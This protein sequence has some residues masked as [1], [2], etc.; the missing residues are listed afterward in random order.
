MAFQT[1]CLKIG[2]FQ[3]KIGSF[4]SWNNVIHVNSRD[5]AFSLSFAFFAPR[6]FLDLVIT[7]GNPLRGV[8]EL[9]LFPWG[10]DVLVL[11][12]KAVRCHYPATRVTT[13]AHFQSSL[14]HSLS[15]QML[16][17]GNF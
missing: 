10:L 2:F 9:V 13:E 14:V 6:G 5:E 12:A 15:V 3:G 8:E 1:K 16:H 17:V 7:E 11:P 4:F